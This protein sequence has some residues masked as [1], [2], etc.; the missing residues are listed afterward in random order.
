MA[1]DATILRVPIHE[2]HHLP[3]ARRD[4]TQHHAARATARHAIAHHS[5]AGEHEARHLLHERGQQAGTMLRGELVTR[6]HTHREGQMTAV[7]CLAA[8]R[9]HHVGQVFLEGDAVGLLL[10]GLC[11]G[12]EKQRQKEGCYRCLHRTACCALCCLCLQK[13]R[14][15]IDSHLQIMR[16]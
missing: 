4:A 7:G 15:S 1:I 9:D 12:E 8:A 10:P 3:R 14:K 16:K 6:D 11:G 2:H 13:Y 5:T